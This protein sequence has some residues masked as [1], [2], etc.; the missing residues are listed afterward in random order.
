MEYCIIFLEYMPIISNE[1]GSFLSKS[2]SMMS[3]PV[4]IMGMHSKNIMQDSINYN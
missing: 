3:W 4:E 2:G 1:L